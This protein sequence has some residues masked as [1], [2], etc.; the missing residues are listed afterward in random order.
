MVLGKDVYYPPFNDVMFT[1]MNSYSYYSNMAATFRTDLWEDSVYVNEFSF[2]E[3][4]VNVWF[5]MY[6]STDLDVLWSCLFSS[7]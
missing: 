3:T 1:L 2:R 6:V 5:M 7:E 4:R